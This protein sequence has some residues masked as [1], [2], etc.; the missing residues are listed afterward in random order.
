MFVFGTAMLKCEGYSDK[1]DFFSN[2]DR[3][4]S[5]SK[6]TTASLGC[7]NRWLRDW[8]IRPISH[9][10]S[11]FSQLVANAAN[12]VQAC[13]QVFNRSP[14]RVQPKPASFHLHQ[15]QHG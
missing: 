8:W 7:R 10:T 1:L 11:P 6:L 15:S 5:A 3:R 13:T 4:G 2:N 9:E 14:A 12:V